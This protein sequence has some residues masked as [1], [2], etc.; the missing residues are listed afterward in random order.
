M[1]SKLGLERAYLTAC[2]LAIT[3]PMLLGMYAMYYDLSKPSDFQTSIDN[4]IKYR[5]NS[6]QVKAVEART[7]AGPKLKSN[8]KD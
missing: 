8:D 2:V 7:N 4:L 6:D 5:A 3:V 1:N